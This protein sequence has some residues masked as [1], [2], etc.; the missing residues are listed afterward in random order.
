MFLLKLILA[1]GLTMFALAGYAGF[2]GR[3]VTVTNEFW[4]ASLP[5]GKKVLGETF[6]ASVVASDQKKP[7]IVDFR[8]GGGGKEDAWDI[9]F[10]G[11]DIE[12]VYTSIYLRQGWAEYMYMASTGFH[13]MDE[14]NKWPPIVG[15]NVDARF[16]PFGFEPKLV[17]FD[18]NNIWVDL[19]GSMCHF[20]AMGSMPTCTHPA[21]PT[22]YDNI[23]K[24]TV[25][26]ADEA[27][28][29]FARIDKLFDWAEQQFPQFFPSHEVSF[30]ALG[31]YAR[32]YPVSGVYL[33][34][35]DGEVY[36][37]GGP[38]G[39]K[40]VHVGSLKMFFQIAGL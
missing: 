40:I 13:V 26:F 1:L 37:L 14:H 11:H 15:V 39:D 32:H 38:F 27:P 6:R 22:G 7:D 34:A 28:A 30:E 31:Y 35:K 12:F 3:P 29:G 9:T 25:R 18:E 36:V 16:A 24:L 2:N 21:S 4:D 5:A 17:R 20:A 10:T 8:T 23:I 33:G 19:Q